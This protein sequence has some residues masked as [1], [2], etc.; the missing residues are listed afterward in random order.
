MA[1]L[2]LRVDDELKKK[3]DDLFQ[4]LGLDTST[5][6]RIFL[7][8]AIEKNGIPFDVR[9][10]PEDLSLKKAISDTRKQ[11][12]LHG[13]YSSAQEAVASMLED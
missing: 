2:Q 9:H 5:A 13:P 7:T 6:I 3:S 4:S 12:N 1:T 10:A 8:F 11:E